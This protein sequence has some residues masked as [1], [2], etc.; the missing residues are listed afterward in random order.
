M[1]NGQVIINRRDSGALS[2]EV[3]YYRKCQIKIPSMFSKNEEDAQKY[4]QDHYPDS[5]EMQVRLRW[6]IYHMVI[7]ELKKYF[8]NSHNS[9]SSIQHKLKRI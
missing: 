9:T 3:N 6:A 4:L 1:N 2:I 5:P 7:P 8:E